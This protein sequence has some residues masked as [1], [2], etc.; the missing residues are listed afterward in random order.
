MRRGRGATNKEFY[1]YANN[2]DQVIL[3]P[4]KDYKPMTQERFQQL[5]DNQ[6]K[7]RE[8][9]LKDKRENTYSKNYYNTVIKAKNKSSLTIE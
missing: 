2:E 9:Y 6:S 5:I 4:P 1:F 3:H 8:E 7:W